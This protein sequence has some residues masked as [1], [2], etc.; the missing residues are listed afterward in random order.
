MELEF[1]RPLCCNF[2]K[3]NII[4]IRLETRKECSFEEF[5]G[6]LDLRAAKYGKVCYQELGIE[7]RIEL[8]IELGIVVGFGLGLGLG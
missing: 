8:R 1:V 6:A 5:T 3:A 4:N 2:L 7:L